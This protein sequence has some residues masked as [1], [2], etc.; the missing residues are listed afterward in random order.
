M[1]GTGNTEFFHLRLSCRTRL[2]R[3][4]AGIRHL[5][6]WLLF[7]SVLANSY[8]TFC[9][10]TKSGAKKSRQKQLLRCFCHSSRTSSR[11]SGGFIYRSLFLLLSLVVCFFSSWGSI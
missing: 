9:L 3:T 1:E 6:N 4:D 7:C 11:T 5:I 2:S 8:S 10:D